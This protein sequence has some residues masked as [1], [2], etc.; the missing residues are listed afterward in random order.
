[1]QHWL[2]R[3]RGSFV[4]RAKYVDMDVQQECIE[5][6]QLSALISPPRGAMRLMDALQRASEHSD[7]VATLCP[8][9]RNFA[10]V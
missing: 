1:M 9:L 4:L 6:R 5:S 10:M 3:W 7:N 8:A 2:E